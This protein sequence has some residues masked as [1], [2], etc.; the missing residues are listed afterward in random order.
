MSVDAKSWNS[1]WTSISDEELRS[2]KLVDESRN[3]GS[4]YQ[5]NI[6]NRIF[7]SK[8]FLTK[9]GIEN[10]IGTWKKEAKTPSNVLMKNSEE[11]NHP[12]VSGSP[13]K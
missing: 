13:L 12:G 5:M 11:S 9:E 4:V 10:F 7:A 1:D 3:D 8:K 2:V 6:R